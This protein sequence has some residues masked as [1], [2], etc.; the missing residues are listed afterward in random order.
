MS[1]FALPQ[2]GVLCSAA[3]LQLHLIHPTASVPEQHLA[4]HQEQG[5]LQ[6]AAAP[7]LPEEGP[8]VLALLAWLLWRGTRRQLHVPWLPELKAAQRRRLFPR[9]WLEA[10]QG[11]LMSQQASPPVIQQAPSNTG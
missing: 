3:L 1:L 10:V 11:D 8:Q 9:P 4:E 7:W 6:S 2:Q 5:L